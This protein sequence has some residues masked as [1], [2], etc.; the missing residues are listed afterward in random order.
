[1]NH[2]I[3]TIDC[4][5]QYL[6]TSLVDKSGSIVYTSTIKNNILKNHEQSYSEQYAS[7][8]WNNFLN[9]CEFLKTQSGDEWNNII[10]ITF[11]GFRD[12]LFF[13]D[14][15]GD[16]TRP[17]IIW[18]DERLDE[19]YQIE[20][21]ID[22]LMFS[23]VGMKKSVMFAGKRS[24]ANWVRH[25]QKK[26][27]E[28]TDKCVQISGYFNLRLT[29]KNVD[30]IAAQAGKIP[31]NYKLQSWEP[32]NKNWRYFLFGLK[33]DK[34]TTIIPAAEILGNVSKVCSLETGLREGLPVIAAGGDKSCETAGCGI[35]SPGSASVSMGSA[36]SIEIF[37]KKYFEPLPNMPSYPSLIPK[38]YNPE[39]QIFRGLWIIKQFVHAMCK[40]EVIKSKI[41]GIS[42]EEYMNKISEEI[43]PGSGGLILQP[44]WGNPLNELYARG[45]IIGFKDYHTKY[46]I[47]KAILEGINYDVKS[48]IEILEKKSKSKIKEIYVSGGGA[49]SD[50]VCQLAADIYGIPVILTNNNENG[51]IGAAMAGFVGIKIY[52]DL[53]EA[54]EK[55]VSKVKKFTPN[56]EKN[57]K[58]EYIYNNIYV[59]IYKKLKPFYKKMYSI[60]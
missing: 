58:Y 46:H 27:W 23:V 42:P 44:Y 28:K 39:I 3:L 30:S 32:N 5:T 52:R 19:E 13:I 53:Y 18:M 2:Y 36:V 60:Q 40:E 9:A 7:T 26:V 59:K 22:K 17:G 20:R 25:H 24:P 54:K 12:S 45:S 43:E 33:T 34:L 11:T 38:K 51:T 57:K 55:M 31:F 8:Y 4:G 47:Y 14:K 6:K 48:G 10:G 37:S 41:E 50:I 29:G 15:N 1:M 16:E 21:T 56:H 35:L 49:K